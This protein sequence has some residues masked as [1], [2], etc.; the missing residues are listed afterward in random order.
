MSPMAHELD[1]IDRGILHLLQMDARNTTAQ[2][3]ADRIG[4]STSEINGVN[5]FR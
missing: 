3:M 4:I 2:V 5:Q 1:N